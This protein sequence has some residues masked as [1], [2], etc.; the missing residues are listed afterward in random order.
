MASPLTDQPTRQPTDHPIDRPWPG[1]RRRDRADGA[2]PSGRLIGVGVGPG[3]PELLTLQALR[4]L[5]HADHVVAPVTAVDAPGRA[6]AIVRQALPDL[7]VHRLP[8]EMAPGDQTSGGGDLRTASHRR[9]A[10][11]LLPWLDEGATVAF[12]TLGDPN[13]YST[14]PSLADAVGAL[15]PGTVVSTVA[16]ICAFQDLAARSGTVLLDG[17]DTLSL[18]TALDGT[19]HVEAALDAGDGCIVVYK[20]GRHLPAVAK[21]LA[22]RG[23]IGDA[24]VGE[25]L[26]LPGERVVPLA[27]VADAP[28]AYLAT[29]IVPPR[30]PTH[31]RDPDTEDPATEDPEPEDP[32]AEPEAVAHGAADGQPTGPGEPPCR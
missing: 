2:A 5:R 19:A 10:E 11:R 21:L 31:Q 25:L 28:A 6:E 15:R 14:F 32:E 12:V 16:G 3:D 13:I 8:F 24:V 29:V 1:P 27:D 22:E 17:V 23:R 7:R 30:H 20:G 9:A 4:V 18:V 26:G